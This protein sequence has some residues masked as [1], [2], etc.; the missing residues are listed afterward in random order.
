M[1]SREYTNIPISAILRNRIHTLLREY[2]IFT[3]EIMEHKV[4]IDRYTE[5]ISALIQHMRKLT[6]DFSTKATDKHPLLDIHA[7]EA[8]KLAVKRD[9][10][11]EQI[12]QR[13]DK[14][15]RELGII[16]EAIREEKP[17]LSE[18]DINSYIEAYTSTLSKNISDK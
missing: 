4:V 2:S 1:T 14:Y 17:E 9:R 5:E 7:D 13:R 3:A 15:R 18:E 10:L 6:L 16:A 12:T 8:T 11:M